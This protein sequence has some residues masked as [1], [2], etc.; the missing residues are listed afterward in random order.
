MKLILLGTIIASRSQPG[1]V[2]RK[3]TIAGALGLAL[4]LNLIPVAVAVAEFGAPI[5][6]RTSLRDSGVGGLVDRYPISH[7]QLDYHVDGGLSGL[8]SGD[9]FLGVFQALCS[10][11]FLVLTWMMR[12]VV[13]AFNWAFTVDF[14]GGPHGMIGPVGAATQHLY[15]TTILPLLEVAF[16]VFGLWMIVRAMSRGGSDAGSGIVRT[17]VM[18]VCAMVIVFQPAATIGRAG[19]L[20]HQLSSSV[21]TGTNSGSSETIADR[22]FTTFV[23]QPWV[24][25][26]FSSPTEICTGT[27]T[28]KD[29]FPL[30]WQ[31]GYGPKTCHSVQHQDA[32][33]HGGYAAHFLRYGVGTPERKAE[34]DALD[35]GETPT[36][37]DQF[38]ARRIDRTDAPAVDMMQAGGTG[39]RVVGL[40]FLTFGVIA[41]I[42]L[43][44]TL[45]FA[46]LFAQLATMILLGLTPLVVIAAIVPW[47]HGVVIRWAKLL[48]QMLVSTLFYAVMLAI[49]IEVSDAASAIGGTHGYIFAFLVPTVL[50]VGLLIWRKQL[51]KMAFGA[52][53]QHHAQSEHSVRNFAIGATGAA[54][55]RL[56]APSR[57]CARDGP[58]VM[59]GRK[60]SRSSARTPIPTRLRP[61][62]SAHRLR[63]GGT[64]HLQGRRLPGSR[65]IR[66]RRFPLNKRL[67][68]SARRK[69]KCRPLASVTIWNTLA[70]VEATANRPSALSIR[71][72]PLAPV[73]SRVRTTSASKSTTRT[74]SASVVSAPS[75]TDE[76]RQNE[77][78]RS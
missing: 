59:S 33:G 14:I 76:G 39:Q 74:W 56:S 8:T 25:L 70:R 18:T 71:C 44:G 41:A 2:V 35:H 77:R 12:M 52:A 3:R 72:L 17:I 1:V 22:L 20:V 36:G 26:Q 48:G 4:V 28:D 61:T 6:G 23:Y 11:W 30:A 66:L 24:V 32:D 5:Y 15:S 34:Y 31:P 10:F 29:G 27:K 55:G 64:T 38:K 65:P 7:Y 46:A 49:V 67:N 54:A 43:L 57:P 47:T 75:S 40:F 16:A 62:A 9:A 42:L 50:F 78:C 51:S 60:S 63:P 13:A 45:S 37:D 19:D 69:M 73:V 58:E 21:I 68:G 53:S